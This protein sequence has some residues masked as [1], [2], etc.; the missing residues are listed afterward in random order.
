MQ[1]HAANVKEI[2]FALGGIDIDTI[3]DYERL[4]G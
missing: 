4:A 2:P 3:A 1:Q